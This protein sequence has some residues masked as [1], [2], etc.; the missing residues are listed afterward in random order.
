[1]HS[2]TSHGSDLTA[3]IEAATDSAVPHVD[4][5][6]VNIA[7][8]HIAA[9]EH[10]ATLFQII[11][12]WGLVIEFRHILVF[13]GLPFC[14]R[15]LVAIANVSVVDRHVGIAKDGATLTAAIDVTGDR[16]NTVHMSGAVDVA[17]DD[18]SLTVAVSCHVGDMTDRS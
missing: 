6:T 10:V 16:G 18:M 7:V 12:T 11:V 9:T 2:T 17:N 14:C 8:G 4:V 13:G 5:G 15:I 3:A 1:M